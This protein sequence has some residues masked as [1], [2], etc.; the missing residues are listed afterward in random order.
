MRLNDENEPI[1]IQNDS[2]LTYEDIYNAVYNGYYDA[3]WQIQEDEQ[4]IEAEQ[5]ATRSSLDEPI[6]QVAITNYPE[7]QNVT[8]DNTSDIDL[9]SVTEAIYDTSTIPPVEFASDTDSR[10]YTGTTSA[11]VGSADAQMVAYMLDIR[12]TLLLFMLL[13]FVIYIIRIIKNTAMKFIKGKGD[14]I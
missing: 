6:Y 3:Y 13:W 4:L 1:V 7:S 8:V 10:L 12:N 2:G 5:E 11:P 14:S 9:T